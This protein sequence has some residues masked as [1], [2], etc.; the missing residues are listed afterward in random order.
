M[1]AADTPV[2]GRFAPSP[3][4][5]LHDGSLIAALGS[6][7]SARSRGGTWYLRIDDLDLA[8]ARRGAADT[9]RRQLEAL[10]LTWDGPVL[11]QRTRTEAYAEALRRLENEGAV[12]RCTCSRRE[13][14]AG[15][16]Y[17][18]LGAIYP[19]TCRARGASRDR[20]AALRLRLAGGEHRVDDRVQGPCTL[21]GARIGDVVVRR[22]NGLAAYHLA[23]SLDDAYLGITDVVR[24]SDLLPASVIQLAL[25]RHLGLP[26]MGWAH[27]PLVLTGDGSD[28][29][30]KQTGAAALD[31]EH[32]GVRALLRAWRFLGQAMPPEPPT[33]AADFLAWG[34]TRF[35]EAAIPPGAR[36]VAA[37]PGGGMRRE[38]G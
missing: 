7:M 5:P 16:T 33:S 38:G 36:L 21:D 20:D 11:Y 18:P 37:G 32:E 35:D 13:I 26:T 9:I 4:G 34:R 23:T 10:G 25:Q 17:G 2:V 29:L 30:S 8:R 3:T 6:W 24:G 14:A 15:T 1:N 12:Y 22:R 28:K 31:P 27:L 19:G